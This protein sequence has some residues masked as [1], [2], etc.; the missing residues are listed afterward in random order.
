MKK[1]LYILAFLITSF[2]F[3]Q[4]HT[5]DML[6][7]EEKTTA[8][9]NAIT[10]AQGLQ[11]GSRVDNTD[12]NTTWR[13][14]GTIWVDLG[15]GGGSSFTTLAELNALVSDD[16]VVSLGGTETITGVKTFEGNTLF[17]TGSV[18]I[19]TDGLGAATDGALLFVPQT[20]SPTFSGANAGL[21]A[22]NR[23]FMWQTGIASQNF[24]FEAGNITATR[25]I[26][27]PD[28]DITLGDAGDYLPLAGN[29][30]SPMTGD[31][32]LGSN[33]ISASTG[34]FTFQSGTITDQFTANVIEIGSSGV[35]DRSLFFYTDD[36]NSYN[37]KLYVDES[38]GNKL[39][40]L[41]AETLVDG[42]IAYTSDITTAIG[43]YVPLAVEVPITDAGVI[44]TATDVEGALQENRTA[45]DV[46][47]DIGIIIHPS[48]PNDLSSIYIGTVGQIGG[49]GL[50]PDVLAIP[51][52]GSNNLDD[53]DDVNTATIT[54]GNILVADGV[55]FESVAVSGD[56]TMTNAGVVTVTDIA[57][58]AE[59]DLGANSIG[60]TAQTA[61][62]DGTTTIDWG[63]G[64][65]FHFQ[66]GAFNETF[67]FT[68]PTK[69]GTF[70]LKL[71][72]D[73]VGS[74]TATWPATVEWP[75]GTAPT[76]TTTATTGTDI[77]TFYFDGT[78]YFAVSSLDFQ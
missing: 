42:I 36:I 43:N 33:A 69:P 60:G 28:A 3:A 77:I 24:I 71:V 58:A 62:G 45:I 37:N 20:A 51:T 9:M 48:S 1:T 57:P 16:D 74:R 4:V 38:D 25:T 53:L 50:G 41:N 44:I 2:A 6:N 61:T 22:Y 30:G 76:L 73:S 39:K 49:A 31:L 29:L 59:I 7:L 17:T 34:T 11:E 15:T 56:A 68:A 35:S 72:Q 5:V 66:F 40:Y 18:L 46:I 67:T 32:Y 47:E 54:S 12:T 23:D 78:D 8:E 65:F 64:N 70:I 13:Y 27:L 63:S 14:N 75:S 19:G 55:D 26:T 21:L 10:I 52:D